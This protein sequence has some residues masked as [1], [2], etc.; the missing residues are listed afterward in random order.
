MLECPACNKQFDVD[1]DVLT[2]HIASHFGEGQDPLG[3]LSLEQTEACSTN[4]VAGSTGTKRKAI[5]IDDRTP[6]QELQPV[7][8]S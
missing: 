7:N 6:E 5:V 8:I 2:I 3:G 4:I 1:I